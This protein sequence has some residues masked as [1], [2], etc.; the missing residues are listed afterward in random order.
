VRQRPSA[1]P[2]NLLKFEKLCRS[3]RL[4][5]RFGRF[6]S[7]TFSEDTTLPL[8]DICERLREAALG[9]AD[10]EVAA[11]LLEAKEKID[12]LRDEIEEIYERADCTNY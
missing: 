5:W 10:D 9:R 4:H 12:S 7:T 6:R 1:A 3:F 2:R 11:L 8:K